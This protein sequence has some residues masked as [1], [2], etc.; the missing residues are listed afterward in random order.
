MLA[1][2][3]KLQ[4]QVLGGKFPSK[5]VVNMFDYGHSTG[6]YHLPYVIVNVCDDLRASMTQHI[7]ND[8][9]ESSI[10]FIPQ[11]LPSRT[12]NKVVSW[13]DDPHTTAKVVL[14]PKYDL[15]DVESEHLFQ[16]IG[17]V[18]MDEDDVPI[19]VMYQTDEKND[20]GQIEV[21][22]DHTQQE[23]QTYMEHEAAVLRYVH[24]TDRFVFPNP[25]GS[26]PYDP[27]TIEIVSKI[28]DFMDSLPLP[29]D[30]K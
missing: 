4:R 1:I 26:Y 22:I 6:T 21:V 12:I 13:G 2:F 14:V 17:S 25:S 30:D 7:A 20:V 19:I 23:R 3:V 5:W 8:I 16:C 15:A 9:L 10:R 27:K 11:N 24:S 29:N 28:A 18:P